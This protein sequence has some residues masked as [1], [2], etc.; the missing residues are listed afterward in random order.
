MTEWE[1][2]TINLADLPFKTRPVDLLDNA[3]KSGW[4]LIAI[5]SNNVAYMKRPVE[6]PL[7]TATTRRK[8]SVGT[9]ET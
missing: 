8:R 7:P 9:A 3:G 5:T 6:Q 2:I 1:Y 4:E